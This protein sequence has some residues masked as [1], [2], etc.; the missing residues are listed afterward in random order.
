MVCLYR[1]SW[2]GRSQFGVVGA[3]SVQAY[4]DAR[5]K[6]HEFTR[7]AKEDDR[8]NHI[9]T[10]RAQTG[11]VFLVHRPSDAL[12]QLRSSWCSRVLQ[13]G[14]FFWRAY[15]A[16]RAAYLTIKASSWPARPGWPTM[17]AP[18]PAA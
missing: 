10:T 14:M 1:L 18:F 12:I 2:R 5:I 13:A 16:W 8:T 7:K 9:V 17:P 3:Y 11:P 6:R 4:R 15:A